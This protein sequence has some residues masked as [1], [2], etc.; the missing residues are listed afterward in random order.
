M[1][2]QTSAEQALSFRKNSPPNRRP[3]CC[4]APT[5]L[6]LAATRAAEQSN[7]RT[8]SREATGVI[9]PLRSAP[10]LGLQCAL[11][12]PPPLAPLRGRRRGRALS[13]HSSGQPGS[14]WWQTRR[15]T[16]RDQTIAETL[17]GQ[18]SNRRIDAPQPASW[19]AVYRAHSGRNGEACHR[20][21]FDVPDWGYLLVASAR[22]GLST[23]LYR[24]L[25]VAAQIDTLSDHRS[26]CR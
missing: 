4:K 20:T 15:A 24:T 6:G 26:S 9:A 10:E 7:K 14:S 17:S 1:G 16:H 19:L 8:L 21:K 3:S 2:R 11:S 12:G 5:N 13:A 22:G 18:P 23:G 25:S